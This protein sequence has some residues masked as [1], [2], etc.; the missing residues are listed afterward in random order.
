MLKKYFLIIFVL[1]VTLLPNVFSQPYYADIVI[2]VDEKGST[3][4]TGLSTIPSIQTP[5][6]SDDYTSKKGSYWTLNIT[7]QEEVNSFVF[8]AVLPQGAT[9]NYLKTSPSFRLEEESG[10]LKIIGSG[11]NRP[12]EIIV[13][14][15]IETQ[16]QSPPYLLLL[17]VFVLIGIIFGG[18]FNVIFFRKQARSL[19]KK[20]ISKTEVFSENEKE[21]IDLTFLTP[22]QQEIMKILLENKK[23][24]Q[25]EL[26]E[27]VEIPKSSI[28]RNLKTLQ[29]KGYIRKEQVGTTNY[30]VLKNQ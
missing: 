20:E 1:F 16:N 5:L 19:K 30:I 28:S 4:I 11:N 26:E 10:R 23:I 24:T 18:I 7:S 27:K 17:G 22:R 9:I 12:L 13:Q 15:S 8:E 14:Y 21:K 29:I 3:S 6:T 25:K 2:D